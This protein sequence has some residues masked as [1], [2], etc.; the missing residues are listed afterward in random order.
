M[1]ALVIPPVLALLI[2]GC[3]LNPKEQRALV[4][5]GGGVGA[6]YLL[7]DTQGALIG[8]GAGA[9]LGALTAPEGK[10]TVV[11]HHH[12]GKKRHRRHRD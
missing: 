2:A 8:G 1:R 5:G 10:H 12:H 3:A 7:G 9:V 11:H 6:G 4:G